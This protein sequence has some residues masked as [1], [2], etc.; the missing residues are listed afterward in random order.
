[1]YKTVPTLKVKLTSTGISY[2]NG[3]IS[4]N[5]NISYGMRIFYSG[6]ASPSIHS[7]LLTAAT[8]A[9][10]QALLLLMTLDKWQDSQTTKRVQTR[11]KSPEK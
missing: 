5:S 8:A 2:N 4:K 10:F 1:M 11:A 7:L 3:Y 9:D 6:T